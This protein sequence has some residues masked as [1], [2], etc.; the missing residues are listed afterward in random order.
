MSELE[1]ALQSREPLHK[2]W[3]SSIAKAKVDI[4]TYL[5]L[6]PLNCLDFCELVSKCWC[7]DS[8][9]YTDVLNMSSVMV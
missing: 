5:L 9:M 4:G 6:Y 3:P 2:Q 8:S 1:G 7:S